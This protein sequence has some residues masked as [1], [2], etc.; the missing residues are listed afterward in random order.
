MGV[1]RGERKKGRGIRFGIL[2]S[3][4]SWDSYL[5]LYLVSPSVTWDRLLRRLLGGGDDMSAVCE[6]PLQCARGTY[7]GVKLQSHG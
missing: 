2:S 3:F 5:T 4:H 6:P 7:H 1:A